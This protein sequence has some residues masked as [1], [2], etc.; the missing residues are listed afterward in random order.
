MAQCVVAQSAPQP[1]QT[2]NRSAT[3]PQDSKAAAAAALRRHKLV[4]ELEEVD[5]ILSTMEVD[6]GSKK[7]ARKGLEELRVFVGTSSLYEGNKAV[8]NEIALMANRAYG[9]R[10]LSPGEVRDRLDMGDAGLRA[11]RVLHLAYLGETL[12]GCMSSTFQPPWTEDG[13]GHWG[14]LV[15]EPEYQ[16]RGIASQLV[17]A[18][19]HRLAGECEQIQIEYEFTPGDEYS[20]R[21]RKWYEGNCGFTCASGYPRGFGTQFRKCRKLITAEQAKDGKR[22]RLL[23]FREEL[24]KRLAAE[25]VA[26]T[27]PFQPPLRT[28]GMKSAQEMEDDDEDDL[29]LDGDEDVEDSSSDS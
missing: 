17:A 16:G 12:V 28:G 21:L 23:Q 19:E 2:A 1:R 14:L 7:D 29:D 9:H 26:P 24:A 27:S 18:A 20:E 6:I 25:D 11:N 22:T 10:R 4:Q 3:A 15:V 5:S 13:C 8:L